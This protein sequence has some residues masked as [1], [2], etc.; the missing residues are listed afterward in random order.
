MKKNQIKKNQVPYSVDKRE[1]VFLRNEKYYNIDGKEIDDR[2]ISNS[3]SNV[4][5][6]REDLNDMTV[7]DYLRW[8]KEIEEIIKFDDAAKNYRTLIKQIAFAMVGDAEIEP[9]ESEE[10]NFILKNFNFS[11]PRYKTKRSIKLFECKLYDVNSLFPFLLCKNIRIPIGKPEFTTVETVDFDEIRG[12][13][14]AFYNLDVSFNNDLKYIYESFDNCTIKKTWFS[15]VDIKIFQDFGA[16]FKLINDGKPNKMYYEKSKQLSW[17]NIPKLYKLAKEKD[18]K[19]AKVIMTRIHGVMIQRK[20]TESKRIEE[21]C[22]ITDTEIKLR[23]VDCEHPTLYR[24]KLMIYP[25]CRLIMSKY[26]K[27]ILDSGNKVFRVATDSILFSSKCDVLDNL[28]DDKE[29]GKFKNELNKK[30]SPDKY[31]YDKKYYFKSD[32]TLVTE[33]P[34]EKTKLI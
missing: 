30:F 32:L 1:T 10:Y 7:S 15:K 31:D 22:R 21:G 18:N 8:F 5:Q 3:K 6:M 14:I 34:K 33:K 29:M 28:L 16:E 26:I 4:I 13:Q 12:N 27:Q 23:G 11:Q 19:L 9:I 25:L 2:N 20:Y 17:G 24:V